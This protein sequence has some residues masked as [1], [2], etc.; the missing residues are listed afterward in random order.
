MRQIYMKGIPVY[1]GR[2]S[3]HILKYSLMSHRHTPTVRK[4]IARSPSRLKAFPKL[5]A[6]S[7]NGAAARIMNFTTPSSFD[8]REPRTLGLHR[9]EAGTSVGLVFLCI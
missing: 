1:V 8:A 2:E 3:D 7:K 9:I 4:S 6:F 5:W